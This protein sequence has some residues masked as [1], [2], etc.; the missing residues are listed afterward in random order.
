MKRK[1]QGKRCHWRAIKFKQWAPK[2]FYSN[3][4]EEAKL[5]F[6]GFSFKGLLN[7]VF[8]L[9][10]FVISFGGLTLCLIVI[11]VDDE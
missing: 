5:L 4:R 6:G 3:R 8:L 10:G 7:H 1:A 11:T 2:I 9:C